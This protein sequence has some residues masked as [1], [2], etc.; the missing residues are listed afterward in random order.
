[1]TRRLYF[2]LVVALACGL[3]AAGCGGDDNKDKSSGGASSESKGDTNAGSEVKNNP[4]V[5]QAVENC[6]RTFEQTPQLSQKAKDKAKDVCDKA[7]SGDVKDAQK[8]AQEVCTIVIEDTV[9]SGPARE[10]A[11]NACKQTAQ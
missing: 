6:K 1:M 5:K 10:Q 11:L 2:L 8:A 4:Q 7:G 9:P 3:L